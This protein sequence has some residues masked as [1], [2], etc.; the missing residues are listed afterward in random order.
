M[1]IRPARTADLPRIAA[2][3]AA[4]TI[5]AHEDPSDQAAYEDAW[6]EIEA[7]PGSEVLVAEAGGS[8]VGVCQLVIFRHLQERGGRCAE[9]ESMHV[10]EAHR[11]EGIG[12]RLVAAAIERARESGCYRIQL[13]SNRVRPDAHR[14]YARYGFEP[15][16][17]GFK[18]Y[19]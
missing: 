15:T 4:G 6:V 3:L 1:I 7:T 8:V 14:F 2:L 5:R 17:V 12:G 10:D 11:S 13:T 9:M 16:H 18:L 19:L